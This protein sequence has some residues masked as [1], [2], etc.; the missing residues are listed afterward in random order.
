MNLKSIGYCALAASA[1]IWAAGPRSAWAQE[2][3]DV[4]INTLS[5]AGETGSELFIELTGG[6]SDSGSGYNTATLSDFVL[7]GGTAGTVDTLSE[8]GNVT[9]DMGSGVSL[10][11]QASPLNLFAQLLTPGSTLSFQMDLTTQDNTGPVPDGLFLFLYDPSGNALAT[12]DP[13]DSN[14]LLAVTFNSPT[15][16]SI[17]AFTAPSGTSL[18][19][20]TPV[21]SSVPEIDPSSALG[22][23]TLLAGGLAVLRGRRRII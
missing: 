21:V 5:L 20:I 12:S 9:G 6:G 11:D 8:I 10:N 22:A 15:A 19:S 14:S 18:V 13:S 16:P 4:N 17:S 2:D 7:G 23:L 1:L 3:V